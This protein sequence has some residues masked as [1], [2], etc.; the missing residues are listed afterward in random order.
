MSKGKLTLS[1]NKTSTVTLSPSWNN[2]ANIPS[3][4]VT[5]I[6]G[7]LSGIDIIEVQD[8][9]TLNATNTDNI[10]KEIILVDG[11]INLDNQSI[12]QPSIPKTKITLKSKGKLNL[13]GNEFP[14][15]EVTMSNGAQFECVINGNQY[16]LEA[17]SNIQFDSKDFKQLI[18]V[19]DFMYDKFSDQKD[20]IIS[21]D[22]D[23]I[24]NLKNYQQLCKKI[25]KNVVQKFMLSKKA[26]VDIDFIK[27]H[28][29]T[30]L[31]ID[32]VL[33]TPYWFEFLFPKK[34]II[35]FASIDKLI[36]NNYFEL[37]A[38]AKKPL[39]S[40][41]D[42]KIFNATEILY[43]ISSFLILDDVK[44]SEEDIEVVGTNSDSEE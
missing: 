11:I 38:I 37:S 4:D 2:N 29:A 16:K 23:D 26:L 24:V 27:E 1:S 20:I 14:I 40:G 35:D 41:F 3:L 21:Y 15:K 6:S 22:Y 34:E 33:L 32:K 17:N 12:L 25:G 42:G 19:T 39:N 18:K 36:N 8:G 31:S 30:I 5:V 13:T 28:S 9:H 43:K 44:F 10:I 7:N